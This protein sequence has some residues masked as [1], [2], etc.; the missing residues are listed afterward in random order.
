MCSFPDTNIKQ[1]SH[2]LLCGK[3]RTFLCPSPDVFASVSICVRIKPSISIS[4]SITVCVVMLT[5]C[6]HIVCVVLDYNELWIISECL[7]CCCS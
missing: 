1:L 7:C 2:L 4:K 5:L 3:Q 6:G